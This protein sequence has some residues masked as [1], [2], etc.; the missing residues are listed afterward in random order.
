MM[1]TLEAD[2]ILQA[3]TSTSPSGTQKSEMISFYLTDVDF[4]KTMFSLSQWLSLLT[5]QMILSC[6]GGS[7]ALPPAAL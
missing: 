4:G 3:L 5:G 7:T 2:A 6:V 1:A